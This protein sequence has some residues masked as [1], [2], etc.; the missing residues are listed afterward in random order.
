MID[1][2]IFTFC[3]LL[4]AWYSY[5]TYKDDAKDKTLKYFIIGFWSFVSL[6]LIAVAVIKLT[7]NI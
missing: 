6:F 4:A 5:S 2:I 1:V 7:G 3:S